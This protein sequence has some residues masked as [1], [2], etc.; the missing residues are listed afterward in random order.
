MPILFNGRGAVPIL[1]QRVFVFANVIDRHGI[2]I[3]CKCS[4]VRYLKW[5]WAAYVA[6][7]SDE[8]WT[9]FAIICGGITGKRASPSEGTLGRR[10]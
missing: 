7:M 9:Y 6:R 8:I 10:D 3:I 2:M 4:N 1:P 5:K